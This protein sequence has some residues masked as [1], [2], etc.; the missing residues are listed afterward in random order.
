MDHA[1]EGSRAIVEQRFSRPSRVLVVGAGICGLAVAWRLADAGLRVRV[2]DRG[3]PGRE[4]TWAAGGMLAATLE[5]EP[6]EEGMVAL[7]RWSQGLWPGWAARL[8]AASGIDIGYRGD[9]TLQ[10]ATTRDELAALRHRHAFLTRLGLPVE[11]WDGG[12]LRGDEPGLSPDALAAIASPGDHQVDPRA[13]VPALLAACAAA[14]VEVS[15]RRAVTAVRRDG[16]AWTATCA[17]GSGEGA[18]ALV[19]AAGS[20]SASIDGLAPADRPPVRPAKGQAVV[21]KMD[22]AAPL[23]RHVIWGAGVY[24]VPRADGRLY[25]GATVEDRGFDRAPTAGGLLSLLEGAWRLVPGLEELAVAELV[26]GL[27][28]RSRDDLPIVGPGAAPGLHFATGHHRNGILLAP[29]TAEIVAAG[30]LGGTPPV[31]AAAFALDRFTKEVATP[32]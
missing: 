3:A 31:G 24:L 22:P 28:P 32:R 13:V 5:A 23:V 25:V 29:A 4:A 10:V 21:L 20:W 27:R 19:V 15:P 16:A 30:I 14:G 2:V 1:S 9:G 18:D 26:T 6:G 11:W 7:A 8:A 12:R 17:D